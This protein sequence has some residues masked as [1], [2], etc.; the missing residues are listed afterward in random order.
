MK[1]IRPPSLRDRLRARGPY[2]LAIAVVF[3]SMTARPSHA[4][5]ADEIHFTLMGQTA[6]T[7]DWRAGSDTLFYGLTTSYDSLIVASPPPQMP[8]SSPGPFREAAL[9]GLTE[10][11][12]YHYKIGFDGADYTFS[13][14]IPRGASGFRFV[15]QADVGSAKDWSRVG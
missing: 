2:S 7:F 4:D 1:T 15:T 14:P 8:F 3:L 6:V 9:T 11:T 13:T 12:L 5:P 10:N